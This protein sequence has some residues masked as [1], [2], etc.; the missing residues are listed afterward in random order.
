MEIILVAI[1][2]LFTFI[3][4]LKGTKTVPQEQ[5][6]IIQRFG[7]F[8]RKLTPGLNW[9]IPFIDKV[10]YIHS[11]KE[12]AIDVQKQTAITQDNV[13]VTLDGILYVKII[14]PIAASYGVKNPHYAISQLV[15]T[16]MRSEI[17]KIPLDKTF[18][19]RE[20][21]NTNIVNTINKAASIWGIKCLR[22]E[23]KDINIPLDIQKSMELQMTAERKKRA[24][25]L[26]SEAHRQAD[27]NIA[28]GKA[29][30]T[31]I[32]ADACAYRIDEIA[33]SMEKQGGDKA[34]SLKIAEQYVDAFKE[35]AKQGNT[36]IIPANASD[37]SSMVSQALCTFNN[38][39]NAED[40]NL[41]KKLTDPAVK[42]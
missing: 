6:W 36:L 35:L 7:K 18:E 13:T 2:A 20:S 41:L 4:F 24:T 33:K 28:E 42:R 30:S 21:L 16:K 22:Y 8:K 31:K 39:K 25:I 23:I 38:I 32:I 1:L 17:G 34:S 19:E 5:A 37:V 10:S 26:E 29:A 11:L 14:D 40:K 27:I 9:I 15:Q 3:L 12:E